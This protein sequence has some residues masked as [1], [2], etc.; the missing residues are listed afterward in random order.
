MY[1]CNLSKV[2]TIKKSWY[3]QLAALASIVIAKL[4]KRCLP[5]S[6][7]GPMLLW[8]PQQCYVQFL[9]PPSPPPP[10]PVQQ[11]DRSDL[12]PFKL[13]P[14]PPCR[15]KY[16]IYTSPLPAAQH[17]RIRAKGNNTTSLS[18]T[19][20]HP[21]THKLTPHHLHPTCSLFT[22]QNK[23]TRRGRAA[24][25]GETLRAPNPPPNPLWRL[26]RAGIYCKSMQETYS[27]QKQACLTPLVMFK[28]SAVLM[29]RQEGTYL[30]Y[31]HTHTHTFVSTYITDFNK[32]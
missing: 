5:H 7:G 9:P 20:P 6:W 11:H 29:V 17:Q 26:L 30:T 13:H 18:P 21:L 14:P 15:S 19:H 4:R 8:A 2:L 3:F 16:I 27:T 22:L 12:H 32:F 10:L 23:N 28:A 31:T 25:T 24:T 1:E